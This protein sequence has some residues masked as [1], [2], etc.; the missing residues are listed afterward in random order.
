MGVEEEEDNAAEEED[1][2][3]EDRSQ[4]REA[5][6]VRACTVEM[7]TDISQEVLCG[8]LEGKCRTLLPRPAFC[9]SLNSQNAHGHVTRGILF[10][11]IWSPSQTC[12]VYGQSL[13]ADLAEIVASQM[14]FQWFAI[15]QQ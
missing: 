14:I 2:E 5:H 15:Y 12:N 10:S 13:V 7:H 4:D 11:S 6:F 9:A 3:E 8:N 1:V